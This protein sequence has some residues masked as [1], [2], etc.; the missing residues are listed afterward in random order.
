MSLLINESP[1]C[2]Q[3]KLAQYLGLEQAIVLQQVAY[4]LSRNGNGKVIEGDRYI[5][6]TYEQWQSDFFPFL[7]ERTIRRIFTE[8]E[9]KSLVV[10]IQPEGAMSRRKYY[11]LGAGC[12]HLTIER[13]NEQLGLK[14]DD[15]EA[16]L[17]P[18]GSGQVDR[19]VSPSWPL[20]LTETTTETT[21][22]RNTPLPPKVTKSPLQLRTEAIFNRRPSTPLT[23]SETRA[24]AKNRAAI[25]ET[26]EDEWVLLERF[27]AQPQSKTYSRK[28]LAALLNNWNGEIDRAKA[29]FFVSKSANEPALKFV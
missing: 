16:K 2:F 7:S 13:I 4:L 6:N 25:A 9:T 3:P 1:F 28:D 11:R 19:L 8:L 23:E 14:Q 20:P 24:F 27:Y 17:A 18:S 10:A 26:T 21:T 29:F 15:D 12:R 5:F 22:E